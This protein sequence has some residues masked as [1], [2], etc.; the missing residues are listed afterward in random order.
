VRRKPAN[1]RPLKATSDKRRTYRLPLTALAV[2][3]ITIA[4]F[5]T[6]VFRAQATA[7]Q[8]M[9]M[10]TSDGGST[11]YVGRCFRMNIRVQT[12]SLNANSV[13]VII[14]YNSAYVQPYSDSSCTT[15]A[16]VNSAVQTDGLFPSYPYNKIVDSKIKVTAY[17]QTNASPVNTGAAPS[18]S[19]LAH[20]WW[21]VMS[22]SGAFNL[23]FEFTPGSTT[24]TNMAQ[25][26]GD[27]SDVLDS[28]E[29][30]SL[31]L[32]SD[33]SK[34]TFSNLSPAASATTVSV[35]TGVTYTFSDSGAGIDTS[36]LTNKLSGTSKSFST[37]GCTTT[38]SNRTSSCNITMSSVGTLS[39][40]TWYVVAATGSDLASPTANSASQAW[41][42]RTEDDTDAPYLGSLSPASSA[43]GVAVGSNIVFHVKDYKGQAGVTPGLGVDISTVQVTVTPAGGSPIVY[44][45]SSPQF[46]YTGTSADYTVTINPTSDFSQNTVVTVAVNASDSNPRSANVMSTSTYSFRTADSS[47]PTFSSFS[48]PQG[49]AGV[50]P[51]ANVVFHILDTGTGVDL[52]NTTVTVA[53]TSYTKTGSPSYSYTGTAADYTITVNPSSNFTGGQVVTVSI[54][55]RDLDSNTATTSYSFTVRNACT[56]CSVDTE[57]P[58]R[59]T[60]SATLDATISFHVKDTG[61]GIRQSSIRATLT[62]TGSAF[63]ATPLVLTGASALVSITGTAADYTV[64]ITLPAAIQQNKTYSILIEATDTDSVPM[65]DVAYSFANI[66]TTTTTVASSCTTTTAT[67]GTTHAGGGNRN[68][69]NII[70]GLESADLPVIVARRRLPGTL[71]VVSEEL[72]P[73][74]ARKVNRCYVDEAE[75]THAAALAKK[76]KY[77]DVPA[78]AWYEDAARAFLQ[79]GILD[80][81]KEYFRGGAPAARAEVAKVLSKIKDAS[82]TALPETLVFD[83]ADRSEWYAPFVEFS[84]QNGWMRGYGD[85]AGTHPC[86]VRPGSTITRAE[87]VAMIIRFFDLQPLSLAPRFTDVPEDAWYAGVMRSA[88]DRCIVQGDAASYR[89]HPAALLTR[90]ELIVLLYRSEQQLRYGTDCSWGEDAPPAN[91]ARPEVPENVPAPF[92]SAAPASLPPPTVAPAFPV[93]AQE[94]ASPAPASPVKASLLTPS[95][96]SSV[97]SSM[98]S[99]QAAVASADSHSTSSGSSTPKSAGM[100]VLVFVIAGIIAAVVV[101]RMLL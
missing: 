83:D 69:Q 19:L 52:T 28:V 74:V 33:T 95:V 41:W 18:D 68:V 61:S 80:A 20:V 8:I 48:P 17:D 96:T 32:A 57:D 87:A 4:T 35:T 99:S 97:S 84:A 62:G 67:T 45:Y 73:E 30:L 46:G 31:V 13:D 29:N 51:D 75:A 72:S 60:T 64:T 44:N 94:P 63:T 49:G 89:A 15:A 10:V 71:A 42:F 2:L 77:R 21:K 5:K 3:F 56:T 65:D 12:D 26:N 100:I 54:S 40:Y 23:R 39:Y 98:L 14:P 88:A 90:A 58:A 24:D 6:G 59:F 53:G 76:T 16:D 93:E 11:F 86:F 7:G 25:Q 47:V 79:R 81:A 43:T 36:A 1:R 55:T 38:N 101:G 27:G 70:A 66:V 78:G 92:S 37:S 50:A 91:I 82:L 22:A 85:C 34:P 9:K